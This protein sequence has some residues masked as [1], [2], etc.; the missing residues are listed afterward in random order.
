MGSWKP[1]C[2]REQFWAGTVVWYHASG[3]RY[4]IESQAPDIRYHLSDFKYQWGTLGSMHFVPWCVFAFVCACCSDSWGNDRPS[5]PA[6]FHQSHHNSG[7]TAHLWRSHQR[8]WNYSLSQHRLFETSCALWCQCYIRSFLNTV[9]LHRCWVVRIR[10]S[11]AEPINFRKHFRKKIRQLEDI[12]WE[13]NWSLQIPQGENGCERSI[14]VIL[15]FK[16]AST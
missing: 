1:S 14:W 7:W 5:C 3:I 15:T 16:S 12:V 9:L 8:H 11:I 2:M 10:R 4:Q 13:A 6:T